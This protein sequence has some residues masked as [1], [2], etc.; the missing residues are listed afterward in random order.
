MGWENDF[1][2]LKDEATKLIGDLITELATGLSVLS[3]ARFLKAAACTLEPLTVTELAAA[4]GDNEK[5]TKGRCQLF[6]GSKWL[7]KAQKAGQEAYFIDWSTFLKGRTDRLWEMPTRVGELQALLAR[8]DDLEK[9]APTEALKKELA[10]LKHCLSGIIPP[11]AE[12]AKD[13]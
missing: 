13:L 3:H 12:R 9:T 4:S 11:L 2:S 7:T 1:Q 10:A 8:A 5:N 6:V